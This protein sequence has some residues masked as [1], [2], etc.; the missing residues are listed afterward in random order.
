MEKINKIKQT[1]VHAEIIMD[2]TAI[3][4]SCHFCSKIEKIILS[5]QFFVNF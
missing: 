2:K 4:K 1:H 3:E 5:E